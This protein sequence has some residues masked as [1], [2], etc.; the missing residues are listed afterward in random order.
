[1]Q[2]SGVEVTVLC[3]FAGH[4]LSGDAGG[5][6]CLW[7]IN[8]NTVIAIVTLPD[9][10]PISAICVGVGGDYFAWIGAGQD[11]FRATFNPST[12]MLAVDMI[13]Q[14][15]SASFHLLFFRTL[16]IFLSLLPSLHP[17]IG[18]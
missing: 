9:R 10:R 2:E 18:S 3:S 11:L 14:K 17:S 4:L 12:N 5:R 7:D 16:L 6:L 15:V 1:M 8:K 13:V